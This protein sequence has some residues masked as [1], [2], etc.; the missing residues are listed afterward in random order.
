MEDFDLL[1]IY[2]IFFNYLK[3]NAGERI[4]NLIRGAKIDRLPIIEWAPWWDLTI[5]RWKKDGL[6][7]SLHYDSALIFNKSVRNIQL[8]FGLDA[9]V[10]TSFPVRSNDTPRPQFHGAGI[11]K[12]PSEYQKIK[13][14]MF[15]DPALLHDKEYLTWLKSTR[16]EGN[17]IHWF[18]V[19]GFF[20][21]PRELL[22]IEPHLYSFY[23]EPDFL[24]EICHDYEN[25]LKKVFEYIGNT[26]QFDF[27][28]FA[29]DMSYNHGPMIGK[30]AFDRFLSPFYKRLIPILKKMDTPIFID[31]D[32]DINK[33]VD[34]YAETGA[35]GMFPLER[36]A[37]VDVKHYIEKQ[38]NMCFMGHFDKMCMKYGE[39]AIKTE[40]ERILLNT[41]KGRVIISMDHQTPPDVSLEN[42]QTYVRHFREFSGF[43]S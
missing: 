31:S 26:F 13:K 19:E 9:C 1:T 32:G 5:E 37:G 43:C 15:R 24:L 21:Y 35:E 4:K 33:A 39:N 23:D 28:S 29:E 20:W 18:S 2:V 36:Q 38:P 8:F 3:M 11:M 27:M 41:Q 42:Y 25:W 7:L 22:G 6:P 34:W 10:Q 40:F 17:T 16:E 12:N 14:T 30:D